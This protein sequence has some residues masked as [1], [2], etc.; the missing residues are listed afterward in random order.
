MD[1]LKG[2]VGYGWSGVSAVTG[3][4]TG[5]V[6][7]LAGWND[8]EV[9]DPDADHAQ[10]AGD[11]QQS[12]E[13]KQKRDSLWQILTNYVGMD[14]T[15]VTLPVWLFE[16]TT[17]LTRSLETVQYMDL[18]DKAS[19]Y[20]SSALRL[21][22]IASLAVSGLGQNVRTGKPFNPLLGETF[23]YI[24][25]KDS[26][27]PTYFFSEQVSHHPPITAVHVKSN[28]FT[29]QQQAKVTTKFLGNSVEVYTVSPSF[30]H[31]NAYK[32][33]YEIYKQPTCCAHNLLVGRTWIDYY[34]KMQIINHTTKERCELDFTPCGWFGAGRFQFKGYIIDADGNNVMYLYG[35]WN[36][37]LIVSPVDED[38]VSPIPDAEVVIWEPEKDAGDA[39][40]GMSKWS[41]DILQVDEEYKKILP[42]SDSRLR[43]D[44]AALERQDF[45]EASIRKHELEEKQ[46]R[47]RKLREEKGLE[48]KPRYF[49]GTPNEEGE[50]IYKY[51]GGYW[52]TGRNIADKPDFDVMWD[53]K[54]E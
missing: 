25:K 53:Q 44:R 3:V 24:G 11:I 4:V 12:E 54:L 21:A 32:E 19:E 29:F 10:K 45:N 22:H 13:E 15:T 48:W 36:E 30:I 17:I 49:E 38:G 42:P 20:D 50:V 5:A 33:D 43:P 35:K 39:R 8:M 37:N 40:Y 31:L 16:P 1:L 2:A 28:N 34:G 46:R 9:I 6:A 51:K 14:V 52:E 23:E 18:M 41:W 26:P 7:S 27:N 47:E